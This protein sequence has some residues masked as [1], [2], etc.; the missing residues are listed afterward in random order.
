MI[1]DVGVVRVKAGCM[2]R[3]YVNLLKSVSKFSVVKMQSTTTTT[4][5]STT[6]A[7]FATTTVASNATNENNKN[8]SC[9]V[10]QDI[11]L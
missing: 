5:S 6:S 4:I 8:S 3:R 10:F 7:L 11:F 2:A 1:C 9:Y